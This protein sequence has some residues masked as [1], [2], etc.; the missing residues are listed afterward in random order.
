MSDVQ[1]LFLGV[2]VVL[3]LASIIGWILKRKLS[4]GQPHAVIDNLNAR[5]NAWWWM[6]AIL[7][8]AFMFGL[9]G[10]NTLFVLIS[11]FALRE[12]L[13]ITYTRRADHWALV[14]S[15]YVALPM[16]YYFI[17]TQWYGMFSIFIPVYGFL[18]LPILAIFGADS[19]RFLE[20]A[21]KIQWG[22]MISVF[23]ISHVPALLILQIDGFE[24][25]QQIALIAFLIIVAQG[26]DV[27]QYVWGKLCGRHKIAPTLSP[28]KTVE[29]FIGGVASA[30]LV[31]GLLWWVTPFTFWQALLLA[32]IICL[33]G[34]LGGLVMSAIK[35]DVGI[36]DWG[37]TVQ[38]HGGILDRL[39]SICF[40]APV[41][42]HIVRYYWA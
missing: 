32:F 25:G 16:Q 8:L 7:G 24:G 6:V 10:V 23:C 35:R 21:A 40:S 11:F 14:A 33:M 17:W 12:F 37:A 15:F 2:G 3:L 31:G 28:S 41:F 30:S 36:K 1:R 9:N 13:T 22:L 38:G 42:F 4:P 19:T 34:F 26:S 39:D 29:G 5:I 18:A 27:L 20:R